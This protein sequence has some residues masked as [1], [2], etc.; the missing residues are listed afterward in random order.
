MNKFIYINLINF[1]LLNICQK[2]LFRELNP[3]TEI[4]ANS[5][6]SIMA[7]RFNF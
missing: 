5:L 7:V 4:L 3:S 1:S 2:G 6:D